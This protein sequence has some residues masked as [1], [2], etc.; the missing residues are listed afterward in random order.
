MSYKSANASGLQK[1]AFREMMKGVYTSVPG[2]ISAL[3]DDGKNQRAQVMVGI[4]RVEINGASVSL[5]PIINVPIHFPGDDY[6]VEYQISPGCEGMIHFSQ[7]CADGWKNTGGVAQNPLA[8]FHDLQD[9][10]FVPGTRS[11]AKAFPGFANNGIRLRNR[12]GD[13]FVWLKSDGSIVA[14]NGLSKLSLGS[15]GSV[16]MENGA[17]TFRIESGGNVVINGVTITPQGNMIAPAGGGITGANGVTFEGHKHD[18]IEPGSGVS[19]GV[20]A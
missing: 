6:L 11:L 12:E 9:A 20:V 15:D 2:Y 10:F 18:G 7:R 8:R 17:G 4:Q 19:G 13:Q 3:E 1:I 5:P 14:D 16:S